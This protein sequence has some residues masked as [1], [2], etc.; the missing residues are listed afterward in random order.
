MKLIIAEKPSVARDISKVLG[1][2]ATRNGYL[3]SPQYIITWAIGHLVE[4]AQP[5]DYDSGL[6]RWSLGSLPIIPQEFRLKAGRSTYKQFKVVKDLLTRRGVVEVINACDAGREGELIFRYIYQMAECSLPIKRLWISSL[7]DEAIQAGFQSLR[8]GGELESLAQAARCRSESDWLVGINGT[9]GFTKKCSTLLS[10]GRVQTPTLAILVKREKEI[11]H[12]VAEP[13]WQVE[14]E[15]TTP[16]GKYK[17]LWFGKGKGQNADRFGSL[18]EAAAVAAKVKEQV[19][20]VETFEQKEQKQ[21]PP[22]LFDLTELQREMNKRYGFAASKTLKVA[23]SLYEEAKIITYP[24]T[25]SRYISK[26]MVKTLPGILRKIGVGEYRDFCQD[27]LGKEK[28]PLSPKAVNDGKVTDHHAIIPTGKTPNL[29]GLSKDQLRVYDAIVRRFLAN[30]FPAAVF[31]NTTVVTGVAG[32]TFRTKQKVVM[33]PGWRAV[34]GGE[35]SE[36]EV[37]DFPRLAAGL[38]VKAA[39]TEVLEKETKPPNRYTEASLLSAMETAGKLVEDEELR[40]AMKHGGLGT[41]ATRA[42]I[43]E[44]LIQVGYVERQKK[45]LIPTEK[46]IKLI[47]AI[48]VPELISPELTGSWEKKLA[49]IQQGTYTRP[50]FMKE[51]TAFVRRI[52]EQVKTMGM[53]TIPEGPAKGKGRGKG[54]AKEGRSGKESSGE[55]SGSREK[56]AA[57]QEVA[58]SRESTAGQLGSCPRCGGTIIQGKKGYGC[59][60]WKQGCDFVVWMEMAGK[61][62]TLKQVQTLLDKRYTGLIKGFKAPDGTQFAAKLVIKD[63]KVIF[64]GGKEF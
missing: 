52:V 63:G 31:Q 48:P 16:E 51:I 11:H 30:F 47:E 45:N 57:S 3:E 35:P 27:I 37:L 58:A 22:L 41:P 56:K 2:F 40:E 24:R 5:E 43:I 23:Q 10:I 26:D 44:R 33:V 36:D 25:D 15:F 49:D 61:K 53:V 34:Y 39:Q 18:Q 55:K 32:E 20:Q 14:G 29:Q 17:G 13:Y 19:G 50:E 64:E 12:F 4:L 62:L 42:A 21:P 38:Q 8:D 28:L 60:N 7:T 6:K 59:S 54:E 9:R 1:S 46:G